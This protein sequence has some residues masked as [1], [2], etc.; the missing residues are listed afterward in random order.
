MAGLGQARR[1]S[2]GETVPPAG[3]GLRA[4]VLLV[5]DRSAR[6]RRALQAGRAL[7]C[8]DAASLSLLYIVPDWGH[9]YSS[10]VALPDDPADL[11]EMDLRE[12]AAAATAGFPVGSEPTFAAVR[13]GI[14]AGVRRAAT[15][16]SFDLVLVG[17]GWFRRLRLWRRPAATLRLFVD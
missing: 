3:P 8:S 17:V 1:P 7:A 2:V 14:A 12:M 4:N 13:G 16:T 9:L 5:F 15:E 10:E 6:G 11:R